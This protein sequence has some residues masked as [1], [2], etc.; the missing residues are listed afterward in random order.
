MPRASL[1]LLVLFVLAFPRPGAGQARSDPSAALLGRLQAAVA[2]GNDDALDPLLAPDID[3]ALLLDF[4]ARWVTPGLTRV[5]VKER[6]RVPSPEG[7]EAIVAEALLE[8]GG[9]ARLATWQIDVE[10]SSTG[11]LIARLKTLS[12]IEGLYRLVLDESK[13]Y[14]A[15]NLRITAEDLELTVPRGTVFTAEIGIGVT[16]V[17]I[18]G[19]GEMVFRPT[20]ETE[21]GQVHLF[22]GD[23]TLRT[24]FDGALLRLHPSNYLEVVNPEAL[25]TVPVD[26]RTV[27]EAQA[28]F[29][30]EASKSYSVDLADLSPETWWLVPSAADFLTE[31]RTKRFGTLTYARSGN[32]AEDITVFDREKRR[33]ISVYSSKSRVASRGRFYSEDDMTDYDVL[34]YGVDVSYDPQRVIFDGRTRLKLRVRAN[35]VA[36]LNLKLASSLTVRSVT[37]DLF[38][39]VLYLRVRN[40]DSLVINLPSTLT[41]DT[42]FAVTVVYSG[43]LDSQTIDADAIEVQQESVRRPEDAPTVQPEKSYLYSNRSYWYPQPSVT[44]Y[45]T[46]TIRLT[47]PPGFSAACSGDPLTSA[48]VSL[49]ARGDPRFLHAFGATQPVRYLGCVVSR[50][51]AGDT[52]SIPVGPLSE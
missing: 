35:A 6:E 52:R 19:R 28:L 37:T 25:S 50:F 39:R 26:P 17:V 36:T 44:D 3:R 31:V 16:A 10:P 29:R 8:T 7:R 51:V 9:V 13:Q 14:Q 30:E 41:R 1:A 4:Q 33:N 40:Q 23:E 22:A 45:A 2:T 21:R 34:D 11:P 48:P 32:E 5:A 42:E 27:R 20:P 24:A 43:P 15:N 12:S 49:K 18:L 47:L 38:G 46:A